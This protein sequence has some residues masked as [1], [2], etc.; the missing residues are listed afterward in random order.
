[1]VLASCSKEGSTSLISFNF[2]GTPFVETVEI[3]NRCRAAEPVIT[4]LQTDKGLYVFNLTKISGGYITDQ[5]EMSSDTYQLYTIELK[6]IYGNVTHHVKQGKP[7]QSDIIVNWLGGY[8]Y[9]LRRDKEI[10]LQ[11]ICN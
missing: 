1:M 8:K 7:N 9:D 2:T 6:D 11:I 4:E 10:R 3:A 5:L